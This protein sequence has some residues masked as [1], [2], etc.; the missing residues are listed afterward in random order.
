MSI[1]SQNDRGV[2]GPRGF[3]FR[4]GGFTLIEI[5]VAVAVLAL[6]LV[7]T[8]Q[9]LTNANSAIRSADRKL[10]AASQARAALDRF[11]ADFSTALL[12]HGATAIT[13]TGTGTAPSTIG[14]LCRARARDTATGTASWRNDLRGATIVYRMSSNISLERGDGRFTFSQ[15]DSA[16]G[17]LSN[18]PAIFQSLGAAVNGSDGSLTWDVLGDGIVRFH[19]SFLLDNGDIVQ[20][21]PDYTMVSPLTNT[22]TT[23][24]NNLALPAN[25]RPVAFSPQHAPVSGPLQNRYVRGLIVGVA[26]L[27]R[28][29]R[30]LSEAYLTQVLGLGTPM[31]EGETPLEVW[32]DNLHTISF[33]PLRESIR[34]Y[35]RV[36]PVP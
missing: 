12:T 30:K 7:L 24:L 21:P 4:D 18:L 10:D 35:Q 8:T 32:E 20:I 16:A 33:A 27:D 34:F 26:T 17:A 22:V 1:Q 36:I 9:V 5:L 11:E 23:F 3:A 15:N 14:F 28:D 19:I 13:T 2:L 31:T 25:I 6:L 29:A